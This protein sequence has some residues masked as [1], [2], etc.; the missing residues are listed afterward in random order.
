M[1]SSITSTSFQFIFNISKFISMFLSKFFLLSIGFFK[2]IILFF[3]SSLFLLKSHHLDVII[4][5]PYIS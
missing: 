2:H 3:Q 5:R 1:C 4:S